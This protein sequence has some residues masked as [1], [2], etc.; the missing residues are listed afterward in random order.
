MRLFDK[1]VLRNVSVKQQFF[2]SQFKLFI[3]IAHL[4]DFT[5]AYHDRYF[6]T[7]ISEVAAVI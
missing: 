2:S 1:I 3:I 5:Q 7:S 6:V 4:K